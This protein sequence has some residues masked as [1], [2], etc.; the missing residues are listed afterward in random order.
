MIMGIMA[1]VIVAAK[2]DHIRR[3]RSHHG[4]ASA[5]RSHVTDTAG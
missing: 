5:V 4:D 2:K 3:G 1:P